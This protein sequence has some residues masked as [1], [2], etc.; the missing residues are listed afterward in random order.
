MGVWLLYLKERKG[1]HLNMISF[2]IYLLD[3][4]NQIGSL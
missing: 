1:D 3:F 2:Y 4:T